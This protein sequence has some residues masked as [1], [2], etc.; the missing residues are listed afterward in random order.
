MFDRN[1]NAYLFHRLPFLVLL[2]Y[3]FGQKQPL[4]DS[5]QNKF[6]TYERI[7]Q[8]VSCEFEMIRQFI[9]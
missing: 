3:F 1:M 2:K 5:A 8:C 9:F 6:D 4:S 7:Q